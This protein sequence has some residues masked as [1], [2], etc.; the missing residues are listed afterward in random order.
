MHRPVPSHSFLGAVLLLMYSCVSGHEGCPYSQ[1]SESDACLTEV[2][3][4]RLVHQTQGIAKRELQNQ[5]LIDASD[6]SVV[7][8][9]FESH[10]RNQTV[11]KIT[12]EIFFTCIFYKIKYCNTFLHNQQC[13]GITAVLRYMN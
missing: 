10:G 7:G 3:D 5:R 13:S 8:D 9:R 11:I 12:V 1:N 4:N 6:Y 2:L